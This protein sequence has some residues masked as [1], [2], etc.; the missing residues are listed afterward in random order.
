[1]NTKMKKFTPTAFSLL[2]RLEINNSKSWFDANRAEFDEYLLKPF[3]RVLEETSEVLAETETPYFGGVKTMFRQ[4]RDTR[5]SNDKRPYKTNVSGLLTRTGTKKDKKPLIYL[6]LDTSGGFIASGC[7]G[8]ETK[9]LYPIRA[10]LISR[11]EEFS[12]VLRALN[13]SGLKFMTEGQLKTMPRDFKEEGDHI[14]AKYIKL[15]NYCV[16]RSLP[17]KSWIDG[18]IVSELLKISEETGLL[19]KFLESA[20]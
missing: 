2:N 20:K 5:F 10:N 7:Y 17:K 18:K 16:K 3:A 11:S 13:E 8:L 1:M 14:H 4:H 19:L 12:K 6:H 15:K 9:D